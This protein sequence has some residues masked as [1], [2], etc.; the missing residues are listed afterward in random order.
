MVWACRKNVEQRRSMNGNRIKWRPKRRWNDDIKRLL[1]SKG[2]CERD[3]IL[4]AI[5]V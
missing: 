3:G 5:C 1:T 4:L 2:L